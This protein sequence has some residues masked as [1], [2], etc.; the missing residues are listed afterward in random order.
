MAEMYKRAVDQEVYCARLNSV[1]EGTAGGAATLH[2]HECGKRV[3][4]VYFCTMVNLI[5][6]HIHDC[7]FTFVR[8]IYV[9]LV[10]KLEPMYT[11]MYVCIPMYTDMYVCITMCTDMYACIHWL[12]FG[13]QVVEVYFCTFENIVFIFIRECIYTFVRVKRMSCVYLCTFIYTF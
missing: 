9:C 3:V 12:E 5:F 7:S 1:L 13:K 8:A 10:A 11:G 4:E 6:V 2:W